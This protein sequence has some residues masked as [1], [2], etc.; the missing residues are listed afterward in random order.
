MLVAPAAMA[1]ELN[2]FYRGVRAM[3]MGNA[4]T[5]VADDSDAVFYNPAGLAFNQSL[6]FEFFNPKFD[7]SQDDYTSIANMKS[8]SGGLSGDT[9]QKFFGKHL[10]ANGTVFPAVYFPNFVMGF[11]YSGTLHVVPRNLALPNIEATYLIDRGVVSGFGVETRGF[12]KLHYLRLG[13]GLKW[14]TRSGFDGTI[15]LT[16]LA[17]ADTGYLRSLASDDATGF[18]A[19]LGFQYDITF[20]KQDTLVLASAWQDAGD[21]TFGSRTAGNPPPPLR[22]NLSAG[23][24]FIH[25]FSSAARAKN[26][27]KLS[28]EGRHLPQ[29][30]IDPRLRLHAGAEWQ[31]GR[32]GIQAGVNQTSLT[33]GFYYDFWL[34]K[35]S[36]VTYAVDTQSLA[37]MDRERRYLLQ[38]TMRL[39][40]IGVDRRTL[41]EDDRYRYPRR[42]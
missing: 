9:I 10:Y 31:L 16:R 23:G 29:A 32:L 20:G 40:L 37:M 27:V 2:E 7:V 8:T 34:M 14:L 38:L 41:K 4:F 5:A 3:G 21:V 30:G 15:P 42:F 17:T 33:G 24:A 36:A 39:D 12:K 25:R 6:A 28:A 22:N 35:L 11:Y 1:K 26:N 18:A 19:T 13:V